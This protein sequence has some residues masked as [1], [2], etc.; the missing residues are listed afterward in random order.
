[1]DGATKTRTRAKIILGILIIIASISTHKAIH[2]KQLCLPH[3]F[4]MLHPNQRHPFC[5]E[6]PSIQRKQWLCYA[7]SSLR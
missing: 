5:L 1:M 2:Q 4:V 7:C 6:T 3:I